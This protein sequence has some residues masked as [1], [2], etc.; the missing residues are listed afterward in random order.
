[1]DFAEANSVKAL[2]VTKCVSI[3]EIKLDS[4]VVLCRHS[5]YRAQVS[6]TDESDQKELTSF[7]SSCSKSDKY[8]S[9]HS[10]QKAI[11]KSLI[12]DLI[13]HCNLPISL[14]E[15]ANFRHFLSIVDSRY[16]PISRTYVTTSIH[17]MVTQTK[18]SI[19]DKLQTVQAL[20]LTM[21]IWSDRKMRSYLGIT[22]HYVPSDG[23][24]TK[25]LQSLLLSC[26]RI[27]GSHTGEKICAEVECIL[28][29][30][31]I[32]HSVDYVITDNAAN[33]RKAMTL[34]LQ[35]IHSSE[36]AVCEEVDVDEPE[37]WESLTEDD[38]A[39]VIRTITANCRCER[40]SCFD[41]TLHL[42]VGDGLKESKCIAT[43]LAKSCKLTSL[44]HTSSTFKCAFEQVFGTEKSLPAAVSTRWNSTLRQVKAVIGLDVKELAALLEAQGY[45]NLVLSSREY[46]Q[47]AELVE[48]LDTFLEAT[49]L[50]EGEKVV[51]IS[52]ALPSVLSIVK[53]LQDMIDKQQLKF[54]NALRKELL[55]SLRR[56]FKGMLMRMQVQVQQ[57]DI[58]SMPFSSDIYII[59]TFFDPRFK[60][61][62]L[63]SYVDLTPDEV[64]TLLTKLN[65][66]V[67]VFVESTNALYKGSCSTA[68]SL[69]AATT[70]SEPPP[71]KKSKL[72]GCNSTTTAQSNA[73]ELST[74]ASQLT[75]YVSIDCP[76]DPSFDYFSFWR[77]HR[78]QLDKLY[79]PA[80]RALS[81]PA[82]S[83]PIERVFSKGGLIMR[84]LRSKMSDSLVSALIFLK[85]N[86]VSHM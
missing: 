81:V 56:R 86:G 36:E 68:E 23:S 50:T 45:N 43:A 32:R 54:C 65:N 66:L 29:F 2:K 17:K 76:Y 48:V 61:Q 57:D 85:C 41:H 64:P 28:D 79:Y 72:F 37:M 14:V 53:Q 25:Q 63:E 67:R 60:F 4:G 6:K 33:M 8:G 3:I 13:I 77:Q 24:D 58:N 10:Q 75:K 46:S 19:H 74:V 16:T 62:W 21:D 35:A 12:D 5:E 82:S 49:Q 30:Y 31:D 38:N 73:N 22:A 83:S 7:F 39:E 1:M 27:E 9:G 78:Q 84:P 80:L 69:T 18:T 70:S 15:H 59:A 11:T 55:R 51:T 42:T 34:T 47:L 20:N 26:D 44:L 52:F 71:L 40:L